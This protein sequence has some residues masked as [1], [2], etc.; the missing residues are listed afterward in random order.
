MTITGGLE[1]S[2]NFSIGRYLE[3][4]MVLICGDLLLILLDIVETRSQVRVT[5]S[6]SIG[7]ISS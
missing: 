2:A 3:P 7:N 4:Q 5:D 6:C 1:L